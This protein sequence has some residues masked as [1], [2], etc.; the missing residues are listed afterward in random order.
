MH[1]VSEICRICYY[2]VFDFLVSESERQFL[3][4]PVC[5]ASGIGV[6]FSLSSEP[7]F[8]WTV[9]G[10]IFSV[11]LL[12]DFGKTPKSYRLLLFLCTFFAGIAAAQIRSCH[13]SAPCLKTPS[14]I[15]SVTGKVESAEQNAYGK[16]RVTLKNPLI[17]DFES[18]ATPVKLRLT[19]KRGDVRP[20]TGEIIRTDA[21]L[22]PPAAPQIENGYDQAFALYFEKIG[23]VG[24]ARTYHESLA[25]PPQKSG[26]KT[27]VQKM[28]DKINHALSKQL[29]KNQAEVAKAL[30]T[31]TK[32]GIPP[33]ITRA[34]QDAGIA[35]LLSV[36]GLHMS[37]IAGFVFGFVR[38][39]LAF[40]PS[41]ALRY[42][43]KKTAAVVALAVAFVYLCLSGNAVPARRAFIMLAF[44]LCAVFVNR[45]AVSL[46]ATAWAAFLI[47]LFRPETLLSAGFQMSFAAVV[48]LVAAYEAGADVWRK[49][50]AQKK[51]A[52]FFILS[53]IVA[54]AVTTLIASTATAPFAMFHF[55]R[56]PVYGLIGNLASSAL[57]GCVVMPLLLAGT[58]LIPI[59]G[60]ALPYKIA[61]Y[62]VEF[63]NF[64]A[65]KTAGLPFSVIRTPS[66]PVWGLLCSVFGGLWLCLWKTSVRKAGL[67]LFAF[68]MLSPLFYKAP[69]VLVSSGASVFAFKDGRGMLHFPTGKAGF[70]TRRVWLNKNAQPETNAEGCAECFK[71]SG[72]KDGRVDFVCENRICRFRTN[73]TVV[74]WTKS[75]R[76]LKL[77]C[78]KQTE[79]PPDILF[80]GVSI[81]ELSCGFPVIDRLETLQKG[82]HAVYIGKAD[83]RIETVSDHT[84]FRPWTA[85]Y[86]VLSLKRA[87]FPFA[88]APAFGHPVKARL[89]KEAD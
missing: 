48:A 56:Y 30:I 11:F 72:F 79:R 80:S 53:C 43:T 41:F 73:G 33:E 54:V 15:V 82:T 39:V 35:H 70:P 2:R 18:W 64:A 49:K 83:V 12:K 8:L 75:K 3:W 45:R 59:G 55:G 26:F 67:V 10:F 19:L 4:L 17:R 14:R 77:L 68:G 23:A 84:G 69:D 29:P 89:I 25:P 61:G 1:T 27:F 5:F 74:G 60:E 52:A 22:Y 28:R 20:E 58:V 9:S 88:N 65:Q 37:L 81:P 85:S 76:A 31:G 24:T 50:T 38:L 51:G 34:Y 21:L 87:L 44:V 7:P 36:S 47:L 86:P 62:G 42:S 57:T 6:Y 63:I 32:K 13:I 71:G 66:M 46:V 78:S 16:I 40:F